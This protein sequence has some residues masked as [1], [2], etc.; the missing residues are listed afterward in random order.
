MIAIK[1]RLGR[2]C[3]FVD[4]VNRRTMPLVPC[5][6]I[7]VMNG[8]TTVKSVRALGMGRDRKPISE[9]EKLL[10]FSELETYK[11]LSQHRPSDSCQ[12]QEE[13]INMLLADFGE[14]LSSFAHD[15]D[16]QMS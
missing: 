12:Q 16:G 7:P 10:Y 4:L 14:K 5:I 13:L 15:G 2:F 6:E 9:N 1:A 11:W 8:R 3:F